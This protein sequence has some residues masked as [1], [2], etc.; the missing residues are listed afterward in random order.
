MLI[1]H[2]V[3]VI[4]VLLCAGL[5]F[6]SFVFQSTWDKRL[7]KQCMISINSPLLMEYLYYLWHGLYHKQQQGLDSSSFVVESPAQHNCP[8]LC[9]YK[10]GGERCKCWSWSQS[11]RRRGRK[12]CFYLLSRTRCSLQA[13]WRSRKSCCGSLSKAER[14]RCSCSWC[15]KGMDRYL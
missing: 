5:F 9:S 13:L 4:H 6:H 1:P 8:A 7:W 15:P 10:R 2:K 11:M 12:G 14:R 3:F